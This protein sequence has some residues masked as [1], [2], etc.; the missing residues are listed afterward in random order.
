MKVLTGLFL[1][2]LSLFGL[3]L[4][5]MYVAERTDVVIIGAGAAGMR[6]ALEGINHT[7]N[8]ILLEK[9]PYP[10]GN[11]N[12]ATAG[13]NALPSANDK[14]SYYQDTISAGRN[15]GIPSLVRILVENSREELE[16]LQSMG[17]DLS[18]QGLLAGHSRSRTFRPSGG[19]PVGREI[20]STLY[21]N[22]QEQSIDLRLENR[23]LSLE[24]SGKDLM[25]R[26]E[27]K[28]G[29][30]YRI[31]TKAVVIATGG[32]GG[33]L[34]LVTRVNPELKGF[35]TTNTPGATG[36]FLTLTESLNPSLLD[37]RE[38]QTHPTV[39]P[40]F[41]ILITEAL[42][43]NGGILLNSQGRRFTDEMDFREAL[44]QNILSQKGSTAWLVF[45][46][47][48]RESLRSAE[49]YFEQDLVKT[50]DSWRSLAEQT[51]LPPAQLEAEIHLW[52]DSA[53]SGRDTR[54][55]RRN[56]PLPLDHPPYY[57]IKVTPG[58]HYCMG[59]LRIDGRARVLDQQGM[60]I[61]GLFAAGEAT[62]GIHGKDRLGGNSLTDAMVF[63]KI[64][65]SESTRYA[66]SR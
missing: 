52:N 50:A 57:A 5:S 37:L 41:S 29:R 23:A 59:G 1:A 49:Y 25:V 65:G 47:A 14:E 7:K 46:N 10:G 32:F 63:G 48:V 40:D 62:G 39:E 4:S 58:I 15:H 35:N 34:P 56:I 18:D 26:V 9:M 30:E 44:S 66:S 51:N 6:A 43:G 21:R 19:S 60:P 27:N 33:N 45:D 2:V 8:L 53:A 12:R 28:T 38:I 61:P 64:A 11:S 31:R 54:F 22:L 36:D 42:R 24:Q 3:L 16:W 13:L 17:A 20:S 55:G